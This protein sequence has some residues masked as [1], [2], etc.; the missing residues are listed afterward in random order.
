MLNNQIYDY[1]IVGAGA[2]GSVLANRLSSD[3]A[4]SV[5]LIEAGGE[6]QEPNIKDPGGFV[7]LW[8]SDLDWQAG[9]HPAGWLGRPPDRDQPGESPGWQYLA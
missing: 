5:L 8:G 1:V 4:N 3:P 7:T 6:D 9:N 2:S